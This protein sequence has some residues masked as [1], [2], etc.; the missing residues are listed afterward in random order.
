MMSGT[1]SVPSP[2]FGPNGFVAPLESAILAGVQ[3]DMQGAFGGNL[4]FTTAAGATTNSTPQGQLANSEAAII[5]DAN[6]AFLELANGVDPAYAEGRMQD[7]IARIYFITRHP[8]QPTV[9]QVV[10]TG[11]VGVPIPG[12]ALI[13]DQS[14][15]LYSCLVGGTIGSNGTVT[16][17]F[18][19]SE[20]GPVAV[21]SSTSC[22]IYQAVPGWDTVAISSGVIGKA[23]E[24][25]AAFEQRRQN[26]VA[27]NSIG[28]ID[29]ILGAVLSVPGVVDAYVIDN[30]QPTAQTVGGRTLAANSI[31]VAVAGSATNLAVGQAIW[32]KKAPGCAYTGTTS[33][34]VTDPNPLYSSPP[35][36]TVSFDIATNTSIFLSVTLKNSAAIPSTALAS[37]QTAI[38]NAFSGA[39]G[40]TIPR[41]GAEIFAS[42]FYAG[43]ASLGSW[44]NIVTIQ[45]GCINNPSA[46]F[47]GSISGTTLTVSAVASGALAIGQFITDTTRLIASG[48]QI[49]SGS[50]ST[51]TVSLSQTVASEAMVG[52]V[53][54]QNDITMNINQ[55]PVFSPNNVVL[56]LGS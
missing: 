11:L 56:V 42:R 48:T 22:T 14:N 16:L 37:I 9:L 52:A 25:R 46:S 47:T 7:A 10:C 8:A 55:E 28:S 32:S 38:S 27:V 44:A 24:T 53:A 50:G 45:L 26:S 51:W 6:T 29:A 54:N 49:L 13:E 17:P 34:V 12:G 23:V 20:N 31:Y 19:C 30:P 39:D 40:G 1:T 15:N 2:T 3:A 33:V 4:N 35:T 5:G 43:I 41:M 18:Q 21:P 36:Y